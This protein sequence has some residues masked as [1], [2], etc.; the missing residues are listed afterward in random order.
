M[1]RILPGAAL[2]RTRSPHAAKSRA[3]GDRDAGVVA[4]IPRRQYRGKEQPVIDRITPQS[5]SITDFEIQ[6]MTIV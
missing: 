2:V 3:K 5:R 6:H 1:R 4:D